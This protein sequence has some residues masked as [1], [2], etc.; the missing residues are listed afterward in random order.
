VK[1]KMRNVT[2][3]WLHDDATTIQRSDHDDDA[4]R[5]ERAAITPRNVPTSNLKLPWGS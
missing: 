5:R 1:V 3:T 2:V 4:G